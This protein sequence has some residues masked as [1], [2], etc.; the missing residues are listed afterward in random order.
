[1]PRAL[2][3]SNRVLHKPLPVA[4]SIA[5]LRAR[6][7][8]ETLAQTLK[9]LELT[10]VQDTDPGSHLTLPRLNLLAATNQGTAVSL[11][12]NG[13]STAVSGGTSS[14]TITVTNSG[15]LAA[16]NIQLSDS[17][18]SIASYVSAS[19][20]CAL[21]NQRVA[22]A[23]ASLAAGA[24]IT[25]TI[26]VRWTGSGSVYD[27]ATVS[28]DQVNS[29]PSYGQ[30]IAFGQPVD[31][32]VDAPLPLWAYVVLAAVLLVMATSGGMA[33]PAARR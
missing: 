17:L 2:R 33:R 11:S 28:A 18:P 5:V 21:V 29:A 4:G 26:T 8:A 14:Y 12:G 3:S 25:I 27:N 30:M 7:P 15:P 16:T 19:S 20:G 32:T 1:M 31:N 22:C 13:P 24:S 9:R 23:I 6:Y 10:G